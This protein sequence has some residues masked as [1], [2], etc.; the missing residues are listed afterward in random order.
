[1][2]PDVLMSFVIVCM[3]ALFPLKVSASRFDHS[4]S[5]NVKVPRNTMGVEGQ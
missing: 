3:C 5:K 4:L 2:R 1:M